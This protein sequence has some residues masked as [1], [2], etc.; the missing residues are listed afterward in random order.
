VENMWPVIGERGAGF[1]AHEKRLFDLQNNILP[2][3]ER[4]T[5]KIAKIG[6]ALDKAGKVVS[7]GIDG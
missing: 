4:T 7:L 6:G 5:G 2:F 1:V 3:E